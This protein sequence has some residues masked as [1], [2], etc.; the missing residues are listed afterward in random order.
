MCAQYFPSCLTLCSPM[1]CSPSGSSVH[2]ILQARML[3]WVAM[4]SSRGSSQTRELTWISCIAGG[5]FTPELPGK[6]GNFT[7]I[8][9]NLESDVRRI[10]LVAICSLLTHGW[11]R[12]YNSSRLS[13]LRWCFVVFPGQIWTSVA[14]LIPRCFPLFDT[15]VNGMCF[16]HHYK[17]REMQ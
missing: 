7:G 15:L 11:R 5:F 4:P 14:E 16:L 10:V 1:S 9:S 17:W 6:P 8:T 13:F 2:G 3:E 12:L